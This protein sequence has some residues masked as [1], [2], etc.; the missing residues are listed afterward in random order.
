MSE[1]VRQDI[2]SRQYEDWFRRKVEA[3]LADSRAGKV[4]PHE[5]VNAR[6]EV[7]KAGLR[8]GRRSELP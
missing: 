1:Y 8:S 5:T 6:M 4:I 2:Q 7:Y 3:G